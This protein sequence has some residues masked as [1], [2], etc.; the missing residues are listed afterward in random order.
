[1]M[2]IIVG[3][4]TLEIFGHADY[5]P[6]GQDIVCAGASALTFTLASYLS[7]NRE[8]FSKLDIKLDDPGECLIFF[9]GTTETAQAVFDSYIKGY[10]MLAERYPENIIIT[11]INEIAR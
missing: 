11:K 4:R 7:D 5:A 1:M 8:Q 3:K 10:E 9:E 6:C 2:R